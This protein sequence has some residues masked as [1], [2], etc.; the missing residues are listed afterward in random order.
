MNW[1]QSP[2]EW[3]GYEGSDLQDFNDL[4]SSDEVDTAAATSPS[5]SMHAA[6][7]AGEK[8]DESAYDIP[9]G[10]HADPSLIQRFL[11]SLHQLFKQGRFL[12]PAVNSLTQTYDTCEYESSNKQ[13]F[14]PPV[15]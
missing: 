14:C 2:E 5:L 15:T 6:S 13:L 10:S 8:V 7:A 11:T 12:V 3:T 9:S 1:L 4:S